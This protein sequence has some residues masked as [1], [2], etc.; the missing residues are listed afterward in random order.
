MFAMDVVGLAQHTKP[1]R[2]RYDE[3]ARTV[4][5]VYLSFSSF[6]R[7]TYDL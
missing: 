1:P 6:L 3:Y 2:L 4:S 5:D 7:M